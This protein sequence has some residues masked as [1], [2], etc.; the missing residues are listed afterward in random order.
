MTKTEELAAKIRAFQAAKGYDT[1]EMGIRIHASPSTWLRRIRKPG[2]L[3]V[4][5]LIRLEKCLGTSLLDT[6]IG[7]AK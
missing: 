1:H 4:D 5:E 2:T 7:G 3:T 6:K